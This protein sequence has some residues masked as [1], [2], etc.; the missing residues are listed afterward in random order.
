MRFDSN[1][2]EVPQ[3]F[4]RSK[5]QLTF[6]RVCILVLVC[7]CAGC[8]TTKSFVATEQLLLSDAVDATVSKIDFSLLA[9][10]KVYL[11]ATYLKTVRTPLLIDSDYVISSLRQQMVS[12]GVLLVEG[13]E[14]ADIVAEAR[15]GALGMNGHDVIYGVP[16]S[17]A[18]SSASAALGGTPLLPAIPEISLAKREGRQGAAKVA[19][20]AYDRAT[21]QPV[22]QS[23]IAQ[24]TSTAKDIWVL[25]VG[26]FQKGTI[27]DGTR[28][29]GAPVIG[30]ATSANSKKVRESQ[31]FADYHRPRQYPQLF[32]KAPDVVTAEAGA[33]TESAVQ[34]AGSATP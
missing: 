28:F 5:L 8:G 27:H 13:R 16:A 17:S 24:S 15:I 18:L 29:A 7:V 31:A 26:P 3:S 34:S 14:E 10:R 12:A 21:R 33:I 19:V 1:L 9:D 30:D 4:A 22:W 11:D 6:Q 25:G 2:N 23:G 32:P 20:F